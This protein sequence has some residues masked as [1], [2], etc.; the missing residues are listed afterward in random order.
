MIRLHLRLILFSCH[1]WCDFKTRSLV[2]GAGEQYQVIDLELVG[3]SCQPFCE[4]FPVRLQW[5]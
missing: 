2:Y 1:V 5:N 4:P 3:Q